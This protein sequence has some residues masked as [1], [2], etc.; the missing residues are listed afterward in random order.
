MLNN[1]G[2][3]CNKILRFLLHSTDYISMRELAEK[4]GV[5]RRS[6]Y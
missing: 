1:L 5:S 3:R 4:T 6:V 2:E